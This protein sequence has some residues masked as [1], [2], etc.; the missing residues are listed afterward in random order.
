VIL[1]TAFATVFDR[2]RFRP[3]F[4]VDKKFPYDSTV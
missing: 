2:A 4:I 1:L 3:D